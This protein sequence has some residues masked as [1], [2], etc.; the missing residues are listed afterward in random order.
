VLRRTRY[1][2]TLTEVGQLLASHAA[3]LDSVLAR[4]ASEVELKKRGLEGSLVVGVSPIACIEIVPDAVARLTR[5][6]PNISVSIYE[7][8][9]G[10]LLA[11]L[12][13]GE[14]DVTISPTGLLTDLPDVEREVLLHDSFVVIMR[15]EHRLARRKSL[16]LAGLR[17]EQWVMPSAHTTMCRQIEA[18]FVA[19][20]E[21]WPPNCISTNSI[22]ALKSLVMRSDVVSIASGRLMPVERKA[23]YVACVPLRRPHFIRDICLRQRRNGN[24]TPVAQRF[25]AEV[26]AVAAELRRQR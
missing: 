14:I 25:I 1:G 21:P 17:G 9:D 7:R 11:N 23:G 5:S 13:S 4:A 26:R 18:V 3:A 8:P 20:N 19:E 6:T 15:C 16:A 10:E 22:T 24:L 2:A 12:R